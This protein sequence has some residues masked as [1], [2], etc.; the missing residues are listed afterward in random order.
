MVV[1]ETVVLRV[2][3]QR[4][5]DGHWTKATGELGDSVIATRIEGS[6]GGDNNASNFFYSTNFV[7][8]LD[9]T[10]LMVYPIF[11]H[12]VELAVPI[13]ALYLRSR[14]LKTIV[15]G[16]DGVVDKGLNFETSRVKPGQKSGI[17][18]E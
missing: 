16:A 13:Y 2:L 3:S 9:L 15:S 7:V 17:G 18:Y 14:H 6:E 8:N 12:V 5:I 11:F 1:I 10:A 4:S